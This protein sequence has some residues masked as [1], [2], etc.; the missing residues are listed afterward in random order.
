[1]DDEKIKWLEHKAL[2]TFAVQTKFLF[3]FKHKMLLGVKK[4][5][6]EM[7]FETVT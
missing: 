3:N 4:G 6:I 5:E 7:I 2:N 1:M